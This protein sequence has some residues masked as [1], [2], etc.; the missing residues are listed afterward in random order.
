MKEKKRNTFV[1][2]FEKEHSKIKQIVANIGRGNSYPY[3]RGIRI[4]E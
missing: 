2:Y 1:F 3:S 4:I